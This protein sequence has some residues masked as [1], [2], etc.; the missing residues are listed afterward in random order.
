MTKELYVLSHGPDARVATYTICTLNGVKWHVKQIENNRSVQNSGIMVPG[1]HDKRESDFYGQLVSIVE[2]RYAQG[3][4]VF[5]FKG[6]WF[7]TDSKKRNRIVRDYHLKSVNTNTLW[8]KN[9]PYVLATQAQQVF[10]FDD[11]KLGSGWKVI[12]KIRHRHVW[13]VP[14]N[15]DDHDMET[16]Y[17]D[18]EDQ[19]ED[20]VELIEDENVNPDRALRRDN[21][22]PEIHVLSDKDLEQS[23]SHDVDFIDDDPEDEEMLSADEENAE[24]NE[25]DY[26]SDLD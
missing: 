19:V 15:E 25:D 12:Q 20:F 26:D 11:P 2:I 17:V 6:D 18:E 16:K 14:E 3:Y 24:N 9:D 23:S 5:L 4:S 21:V 10:Y 7:N 8:Y 22:E 1:S 13:D